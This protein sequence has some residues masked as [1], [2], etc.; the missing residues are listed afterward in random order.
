MQPIL[1]ILSN[2]YVVSDVYVCVCAFLDVYV[3]MS[4]HNRG[5]IKGSLK[6]L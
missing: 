4:N 2:I 1:F 6:F 5:A 3:Y